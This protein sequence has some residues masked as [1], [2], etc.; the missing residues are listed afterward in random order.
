MV[1]VVNPP[2]M[3]GPS[4]TMR[5]MGWH[6]AI[7]WAVAIALVPVLAIGLLAGG[8]YLACIFWASRRCPRCRKRYGYKERHWGDLHNNHRVWVDGKK[9]APKHQFGL[10]FRCPHCRKLGHF[11][12][13]H[14]F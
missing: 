14:P 6:P 5:I 7:T 11:E 2:D 3:S 9:P 8:E 10:A 4:G 13:Q 12:R 1:Q